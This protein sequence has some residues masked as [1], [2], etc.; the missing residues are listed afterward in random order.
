M[1]YIVYLKIYEYK[2]PQTLCRFFIVLMMKRGQS[3]HWFV[4]E[5]SY[6]RRY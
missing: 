2:Y 6:L 3:M 5:V 1:F 4:I